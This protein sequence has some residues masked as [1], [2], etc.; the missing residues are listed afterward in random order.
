[1]KLQKTKDF[2]IDGD[3]G[4]KLLLRRY[5][6]GFAPREKV[7]I[8]AEASCFVPVFQTESVR[9]DCIP[10]V[11][12]NNRD[13]TTDEHGFSG[14]YS[15]RKSH[16]KDEFDDWRSSFIIRVYPWFYFPFWVF[17]ARKFSDA[18]AGVPPR[19]GWPTGCRGLDLAT[20]R[21]AWIGGGSH[22]GRQ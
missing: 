18:T 19:N 9:R 14:S 3:A 15:K 4:R 10:N 21:Y 11:Q 22:G 6:A 5:K 17:K 13:G 2:H 12:P 20:G 8:C 7:L 1:M 16:S